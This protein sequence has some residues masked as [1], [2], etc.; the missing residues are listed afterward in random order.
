MGLGPSVHTH[1]FGSML[2]LRT[3]CDA[4][5]GQSNA[6]QLGALQ[7]PALADDVTAVRLS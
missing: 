2:L 7:S 6:L 4:F 3:V 1:C 5:F